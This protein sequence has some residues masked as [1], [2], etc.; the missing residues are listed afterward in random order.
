MSVV[1]GLRHCNQS[2]PEAAR[3]EWWFGV[4]SQSEEEGQAALLPFELYLQQALMVPCT[5]VVN[6]N[7]QL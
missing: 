4:E 2:E 7:Q 1:L 5:K 3:L 6:I